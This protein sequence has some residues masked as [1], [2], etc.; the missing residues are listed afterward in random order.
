MEWQGTMYTTS[1]IYYDTL[2]T[3]EGCDSVI[4]V[5]LTINNSVNGD[6]ISM[7]AC[8]SAVWQGTP[9]L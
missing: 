6:T 3:A 2:Q 9:S 5:N 4:S 7:I 1:G 8:D